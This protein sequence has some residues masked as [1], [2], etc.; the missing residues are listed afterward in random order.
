MKWTLM[1]LMFVV[2]AWAQNAPQPRSR[3]AWARI[4]AYLG[5]ASTA[6]FVLLGLLNLTSESTMDTA[7]IGVSCSS[8]AITIGWRFSKPWGRESTDPAGYVSAK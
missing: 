1:M 6:G 8:I 3:P 4:L 2:G 5:L 7:I